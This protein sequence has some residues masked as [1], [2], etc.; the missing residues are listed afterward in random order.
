MQDTPSDIHITFVEKKS[1]E[2]LLTTTDD[3]QKLC[4]LKKKGGSNSKSVYWLYN[5][6]CWLFI[7]Y[8]E[9]KHV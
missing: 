1:F 6:V 4:E 9:Q 8:S 2:K 5:Y 3:K 7:S